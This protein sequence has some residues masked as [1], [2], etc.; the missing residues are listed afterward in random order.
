M[1]THSQIQNGFVAGS[2]RKPTNCAFLFLF[3][4]FLIAMV[5][6][7]VI[8]F[9][10]GDPHTLIAGV[11]SDGRICGY[12]DGVTKFPNI[13]YF[14]LKDHRLAAGAT[15]VKS[16]PTT[17]G[18]DVLACAPTTILKNM[19]DMKDDCTART[20]YATQEILGYCVPVAADTF[21]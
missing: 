3:L 20:P 14:L 10:K 2:E 11:D 13:Y 6:C 12:S 9:V 8:G 4:A 15:C 16:C 17:D 19:K 21:A 18:N 7:S 5:V 1:A